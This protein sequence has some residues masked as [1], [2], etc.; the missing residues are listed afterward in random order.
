MTQAAPETTARGQQPD[1]R[2]EW[3]VTGDE[4]VTNTK[5][6]LHEGHVRRIIIKH[7]GQTT[8]E[9]PLT[10]AIIGTLLAPWLAAIGALIALLTNCTFEVVRKEHPGEPP[11]V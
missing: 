2:E 10:V 3:R 7:E 9:I 4:V 5:R 1:A 8:M 6:L 11:T